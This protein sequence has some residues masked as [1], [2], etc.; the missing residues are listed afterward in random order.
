[1]PSYV[2]ATC[3]NRPAASPPAETP[4]VLPLVSLSANTS[5]RPSIP[6]TNE[7]DPSKRLRAMLC[8]PVMRSGLIQAATVSP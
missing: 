5:L 2:A 1:M 7:L 8:V 6:S 3:V 4:T